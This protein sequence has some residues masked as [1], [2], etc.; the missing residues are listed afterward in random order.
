M[1]RDLVEIRRVLEQVLADR[2]SEDDAALRLQEAVVPEPAAREALRRS[3]DLGAAA[4]I[5]SPMPD[6]DRAPAQEGCGSRLTANR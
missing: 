3:Q 6:R 4:A 2:I 1:S 5:A